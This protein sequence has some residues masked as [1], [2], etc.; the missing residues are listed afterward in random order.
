M[1]GALWNDEISA[2]VVSYN[3]RELTVRCVESLL[4]CG[5]V[6]EVC[7]VDNASLDGTVE[8]LAALP[9]PKGTRLLVK[10]LKEN[11]GFG[12]ANNRGFEEVRGGYIALVNSDAFVSLGAMEGLRSYL[13]AHPEAGVVGPC[14][15]NADGSFQESRFAFPSPARAWAENTG[16]LA[17]LKIAGMGAPMDR[18]SAGR[19]DW[20]G[21][22][23]LMVRREVW[24]DTGGFDS[25]FFLYSEETDWQRR[26]Q[27]QGWEIHWV[28]E[29]AVTHLG[30]GSG[31]AEREAV[32]EHFFEGVDRYFWKHHG[33]I[34]VV[35]LR[36]AMI[37]GAV[38]RWIR[39]AAKPM[40]HT[41]LPA[42]ILHRQM[43]REFPW[44]SGGGPD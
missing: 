38:L 30:G 42:W 33:K 16:V 29:I 32:R 36:C 20:L 26:I 19:V 17:L 8:A 11:I 4:S 27:N 25:A 3:T 28:P 6:R 43:T 2:V 13:Q 22:A 34:G 40:G 24:A 14:L 9:I 23:C 35:S 5:S 37:I 41:S 10:R 39:E 31:L 1:G 21:G 18:R 15:L 12:R 7:V 44:F